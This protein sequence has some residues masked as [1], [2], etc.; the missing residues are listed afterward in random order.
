MFT[1]WKVPS[2]V[3]QNQVE[4][5]STRKGRISFWFSMVNGTEKTVALPISG[6]S[7]QQIFLS[8]N[9]SYIFAKLVYSET[10]YWYPEFSVVDL[11]TK[12]DKQ[13]KR[14]LHQVLRASAPARLCTDIPRHVQMN[15]REPCQTSDE[16]R[17]IACKDLFSQNHFSVFVLLFFFLTDA[18][19]SYFGATG[20]PFLD[21]SWHLL[22]VSKPQWVLPSLH[23]IAKCNV[24]SLRSTSVLHVANLLTVSLVGLQFKTLA[25]C[26]HL[27]QCTPQALAWSQTPAI[28]VATLH[29]TTAL[30]RLVDISF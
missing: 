5:K 20:T 29:V 2:H 25:Q 6:K 11:P 4:A 13:D 10:I 1:G 27:Y 8:T 14:T 12:D 15:S 17:K 22:W 24:C 9:Y 19:T 21:F 28:R 16:I 7:F 23:C 26:H 3:T 18:F 30:C